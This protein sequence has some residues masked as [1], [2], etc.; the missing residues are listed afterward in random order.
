MTPR[1]LRMIFTISSIAAQAGFPNQ[2]S[3]MMLKNTRSK[4]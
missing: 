3:K 1:F 2:N 4:H